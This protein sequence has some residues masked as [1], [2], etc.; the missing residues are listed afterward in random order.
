MI[1]SIKVTNPLG[2]SLTMELAKPE[3]SGFLIQ[4]IDGL[5]PVKANINT[6][7]IAM[8]NGALYNSSYLDQRSIV[9]NLLFLDSA[10][11]SIEDKRHESYK[12]FPINKKISFVIE[13]DKRILET[14]GIVESNEPNIFSSAEGCT[15]TISCNDPFLYSVKDNVLVFS[16]VNPLFQFPFINESTTEAE[17]QFGT[18]ETK[19]AANLYY[20]GDYEVGLTLIMNAIGDVTNPTIYNISTGEN[21]TINTNKLASMT[22]ST[23]IIKGDMIT[24]E[25]RRRQKSI[26]LLRDGNFINILNCLDKGAK[27]FTLKKGDNLFAYTAEVGLTNLQ[28]RI[29]NKVV[30]EGV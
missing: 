22:D 19:T 9:I 15:I 29:I 13:T 20:E 5:G 14:S 16:Y 26:T 18:I 17:L 30:Y 6:T 27:W 7:K 4:S 3:K 11:K 2:E 1:K 24:I 21:M 28:F 12:Y 23:G 25:T 10:T 8:S